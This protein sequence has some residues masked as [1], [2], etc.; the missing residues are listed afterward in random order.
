MADAAA[1]QL[2]DH[3]RGERGVA[4]G[5]VHRERR[6]GSSGAG[7]DAV[8]LERRSSISD[9]QAGPS[10]QVEQAVTQLAL[11]RGDRVREQELGRE[12]VGQARRRRRRRAATWAAWAAAA[13]PTGPSRALE[14]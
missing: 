10:G 6:N 3:R 14:R 1:R 11:H 8:A 7:L 12:P 13:I 9:P 2:L 4:V 5:R